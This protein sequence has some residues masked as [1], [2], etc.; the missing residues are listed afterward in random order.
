[1]PAKKIIP[2]AAC[3]SDTASGT[4]PVRGKGRSPA[5]PRGHKRNLSARLMRTPGD[6]KGSLMQL[7]DR[8]NLRHLRDQAKDLVRSGAAATLADAQFRIARQYEFASWPKL[9]QHVE[10][11]ELIGQL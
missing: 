2:S 8:P 3:Y 7:P 11:L 9:K 6:G 1:M 5:S 4:H 10:S